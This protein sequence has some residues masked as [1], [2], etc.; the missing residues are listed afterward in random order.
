MCSLETSLK[1]RHMYRYIHLLTN[2]EFH[3]CVP[4]RRVLMAR[5]FKLI[6]PALLRI[7]TWA[8]A[9]IW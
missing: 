1:R 2:S 9:S 7:W 3:L 6:D 5:G 4:I 8:P